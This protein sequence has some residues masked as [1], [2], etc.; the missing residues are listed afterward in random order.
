MSNKENDR[1]VD[2]IKDLTPLDTFTLDKFIDFFREKYNPSLYESHYAEFLK[3]NISML[4]E[5]RQEF[6]TKFV[7]DIEEVK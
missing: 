4:E 2:N 6:E 3:L 1:I 5:A 7:K